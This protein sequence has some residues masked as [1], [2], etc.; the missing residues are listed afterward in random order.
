VYTQITHPWTAGWGCT[1]SAVLLAKHHNINIA[2]LVRSSLYP[3]VTADEVMD[4]IE[5]TN[6]CSIIQPIQVTLMSLKPGIVVRDYQRECVDTVIAAKSGGFIIAPCAAGKTFMALLLAVQ[7]GGNFMVLT[8]RYSKQWYDTIVD[9]FVPNDACSIVHL[10][11][12]SMFSMTTILA[13]PTIFISTYSLFLAHRMSLLVRS[14]RQQH[15]ETL[16]LDEGHSAAATESLNLIRNMNYHKCFV[17]TATPIRE[18][19]RLEALASH[20]GPTLIAI[21]RKLLEAKGYI[22]TVRCL[23]IRLP[24]TNTYKALMT[25]ATRR[26]HILAINPVKMRALD[27]SLRLL[28]EQGHKTLVFCDDLFCLQW[29]YDCMLA[30]NHTLV[31]KI[32]MHT[33]QRERLEAITQ[34]TCNQAPAILFISRTGDEALDIPE[35][36]AI[37][38]FW[39]CWASR[40]QIIQRIGRISRPSGIDPVSILLYSNTRRDISTIEHRTEY[41]RTHNYDVIEQSIR[42]SFLWTKYQQSE[43]TAAEDF[44]RKYNTTVQLYFNSK[45]SKKKKKVKRKHTLIAKLRRKQTK[46]KNKSD[47]L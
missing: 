7:R 10:T 11:S 28:H 47:L 14:L 12:R 25:N 29:A 26:S 19:D 23:N 33:P 1:K 44:I 41:L 15:I 13:N 45:G 30:L 8:T 20:I 32:S 27:A 46:Q 2:S 6:K 42:N 18:D 37:V 3:L 39:N 21:D 17:F 5:K 34:F 31:N 40:R 36:S 9:F 4:A 22:A 16:I 38:M 43:E 24:Y 35:A